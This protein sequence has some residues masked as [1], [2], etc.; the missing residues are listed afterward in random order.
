MR[1]WMLALL[2]YAAVSVGGDRDTET[3]SQYVRRVVATAERPSALPNHAIRNFY[4]SEN[5]PA[6]LLAARNAALSIKPARR[7]QAQR[8]VEFLEQIGLPSDNIIATQSERAIIGQN[9]PGYIASLP[10]DV[11]R[12]ARYLSKFVVGAGFGLFDYSLNAIWN[13]VVSRGRGT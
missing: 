5:D 7:P 1:T 10:A 2:L 3:S 9:L 13:E 12:D 8:V 11:K 6:V 4:K